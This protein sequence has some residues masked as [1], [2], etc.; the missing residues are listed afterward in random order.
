MTEIVHCLM[1][2]HKNL[3]IRACLKYQHE[4]ISI[5]YW[6][7]HWKKLNHWDFSEIR[8]RQ[9]T[10]SVISHLKISSESY[11]ISDEILKLF[12][13][14]VNFECG[15]KTAASCTPVMLIYPMTFFGSTWNWKFEKHA[16]KPVSRRKRTPSRQ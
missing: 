1:R 5:N 9:W 16:N 13:W 12:L 3:N 2:S 8:M 4:I 6:E 15:F 11:K 14:R 10:I 7:N